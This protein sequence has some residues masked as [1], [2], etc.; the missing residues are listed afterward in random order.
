MSDSIR[1]QELQHVRLPCPS[2]SP[3]ICSNSC[4]LSQWCH[5]TISSSVVPFSSCPQSFP[6]SGSSPRSH[7]FTS[8]GQ[9]IG[10]FASASVLPGKVQ[11]WYPLGQTALITLQS[12][13]LSRIFSKTTIQKHQFFSAQP[14]LWPNLTSIQATRKTKALHMHLCHQRGTSPF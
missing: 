9:N 14:S 11:G 8:G 4:P 7:F 2:L 10:T 6:A 12:K 1:P 3:R 5:P 13:R